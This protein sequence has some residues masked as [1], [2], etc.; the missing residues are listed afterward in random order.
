MRKKILA[1]CLMTSLLANTGYSIHQAVEKVEDA[2]VCAGI[3]CT[4]PTSSITGFVIFQILLLGALPLIV[5]GAHSKLGNAWA[6]S[7][8][9]CG[10]EKALCIDWCTYGCRN[11]QNQTCEPFGKSC[12][13]FCM[14]TVENYTFVNSV[15]TCPHNGCEGGVACVPQGQAVVPANLHSPRDQG[16]IWGRAMV[17]VGFAMVIAGAS[18]FMAGIFCFPAKK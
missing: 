18:V 10:S 13:N 9:S 12:E 14:L 3:S 1:L 11:A 6:D 5:V 16:T 15:S 17:A 4:Q 8:P 2:F 7:S